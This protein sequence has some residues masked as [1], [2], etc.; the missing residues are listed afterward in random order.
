[1]FRQSPK[2]AL[3]LAISALLWSAGHAFAEEKAQSF[4]ADNARAATAAMD[5]DETL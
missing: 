5:K 4:N 2:F 3:A 1:M